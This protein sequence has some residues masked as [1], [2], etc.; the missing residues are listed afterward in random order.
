MAQSFWIAF[1]VHAFGSV[2]VQGNRHCEAYPVAAKLKAD[3]WLCGY[4]I[5]RS[6]ATAA[7]ANKI[8]RW[9][10]FHPA[11]EADADRVFAG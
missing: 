3:A 6:S 9:N 5:A 4:N 11:A 2:S 1:V 7:A 8:L 10:A